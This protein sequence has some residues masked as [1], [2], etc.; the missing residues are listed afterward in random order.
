MSHIWKSAFFSV[1]RVHGIFLM[2]FLVIFD[3]KG[4]EFIFKFFPFLTI[5][6]AFL[7]QFL[8]PFYIKNI[9]TRR[10]KTHQMTQF[11]G[12]LSWPLKSNF[13]TLVH[14][15]L[16]FY[17]F[18]HKSYKLTMQVQFLINYSYY[19]RPLTSKY[20]FLLPQASWFL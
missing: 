3:R 16:K 11:T 2:L 20:S 14:F 13:P 17:S 15:T 5:F 7:G 6:W 10:P 12:Y 18:Y 8:I 4:L 9:P 19:M 1:V